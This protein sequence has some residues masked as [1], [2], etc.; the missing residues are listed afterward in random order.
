MDTLFSLINGAGYLLF[1]LFAFLPVLIVVVVI[2]ELGHFLVAR[3]CGVQVSAFS[4][5]FGREIYAFEDRHGTRWRLAWLPLGGYVKFVDDEN[6]ASVPTSDARAA[7]S[8]EERSG[9]FHA[10]PVWQR[11]AVVAA[12]PIANF[13]L[14]IV[15]FAIMFIT[16]GVVKI[17]PRVSAVVP[18]TPA[19]TAGFKAG[20]LILSIDGRKIDSFSD[21]QQYVATSPGRNLAFVVARDGAEVALTVKPIL[22]ESVDQIAG[23]HVRPVIGIQSSRE[24]SQISHTNVGVFEAV[25]LGVQRTWSIITQTL[26]YIG[27][28]FM[29]RQ[30]AD[31]I[32]GVIGIADVSGKVAQLG[33]EYVIQLIALI[34]VSIGLI[35]LFP[36]PMLDGGHLLFYF[37]E[38]L[39]GRPLSEKTQEFSFKVGF[40]I[41]IALMLF[42]TWND[43]SRILANTSS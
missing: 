38:A 31:Q 33:P 19:A 24:V 39:R 22:K 26:S 2:H 8:V 34:S 32:G 15:I 5:G 7:M 20:D 1:V 13:L 36:V 6:P 25:G 4:V 10:K 17:E 30:P 37:V 16:F 27:D 23:K 11:A 29:Q 14:A 28:V 21:I 9:S 43:I 40:A 41:V 18:D 3:W 35:N 42:T 12:G